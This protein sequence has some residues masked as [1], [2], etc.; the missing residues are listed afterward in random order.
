LASVPRAVEAAEDF[1]VLPSDERLRPALGG[2]FHE[3][4][5]QRRLRQV[6]RLDQQ[7]L[8]GGNPATVIE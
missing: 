7:I 3:P 5:N 4:A 1:V 8:P 2:H 6:D